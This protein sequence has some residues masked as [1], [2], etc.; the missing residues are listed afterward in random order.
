MD[1]FNHWSHL[2]PKHHFPE[3]LK[4]R[5]ELGQQLL[6]SLLF[7]RSAQFGLPAEFIDGHL[8][9]KEMVFISCVGGKDLY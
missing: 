3:L 6:I 4:F 9:L 7:L 2:L 8:L 1:V 5:D